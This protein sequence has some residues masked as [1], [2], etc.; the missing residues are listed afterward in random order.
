MRGIR[1]NIHDVTLHAD[2]IHRGGGQI[3]PTT[4]R[5][6]YACQLTAQPRIM[7][8]VFLVEIQV[9][10]LH[11]TQHQSHWWFWG[12][13]L[14]SHWL[15]VTQVPKTSAGSVYGVLSSRRGVPQGEEDVAG[16]PMTM[17]K[18]Y[19]PVMES[20]GKYKCSGTEAI[21]PDCNYLL[22]N[23]DFICRIHF[24]PPRSQRWSSLPP[25]CVRSLADHAWRS[26]WSY[27][28][29]WRSCH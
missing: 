14:Y 8:P 1:F 2:A 29:P 6:L 4:R 22:Q 19:L 24:R 18:A 3:I 7:E 11:P 12:L 20:F 25:V 21:M 23:I 13:W 27:I 17:S 10:Y 15:F 16:T 9:R 28:H 5:C 26:I